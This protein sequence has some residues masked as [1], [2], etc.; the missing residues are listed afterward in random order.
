MLAGSLL[1]LVSPWAVRRLHSHRAWVVGC[2]ACQ[3]ASLLLLALLAFLPGASG[4]WVFFPATIYWAAGLA[5]GPAWNSWVEQLIPRSM[6]AAFF[7]QRVRISHICV[8]AGLIAGGVLLPL[9]SGQTALLLFALLFLVAA[10]SRFYSA[11]MLARQS[12]P[13]FADLP[14]PEQLPLA[15][16]AE[17]IERGS[18]VRL[19]IYLLG[20]QASVYIAAPYFTPYMLGPLDLS[21]A[22]YM[23]LLSC[24]FLGKIVAMPW[25][26]RFAKRLGAGKLLWIGG[27]SIIPLSAM[28]L[29]SDS[30]AYLIVLQIVGGMAWA[31]YELAMF[32]LFFE[33]IP[34]SRR[35]GML[36]LYNLGNCA[37]MVVGS[38]IGAGLMFYLGA[39]REAYLTVFAA[40]A[41]ARLCCLVLAPR[42][43]KLPKQVTTPTQRT[44]A[45]RPMSGSIERPILP[46]LPDEGSTVEKR[47]ATAAST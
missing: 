2:A 19:L 31:A 32:L 26:G 21:Y 44:I 6:R 9:G 17:A 3:A 33:T 30:L 15:T 41:A 10:L 1:Q 34:R 18:G 14:A 4:W 39:Q 29:I 45:V 46:V 8:L 12:E 43:P 47:A 28:W 38:L 11:A 16:G 23:V 37:A 40:S 5:T 27:V 24:G 20:M 13:E 42:K 7:A 22:S 36:T 35:I 25:V